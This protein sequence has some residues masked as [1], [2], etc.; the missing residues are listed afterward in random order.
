MHRWIQGQCSV[1]LTDL[2]LG[3]PLTS[4][5]PRGDWREF[6]DSRLSTGSC[7]NWH[8]TACKGQALKGQKH[9]SARQDRLLKYNGFQSVRLAQNPWVESGCWTPRTAVGEELAAQG[10]PRQCSLSLQAESDF[11]TGSGP[12][13]KRVQWPGK[14]MSLQAYS[15]PG[16]SSSV[17]GL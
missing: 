4:R 11:N 6:P 7:L 1:P 17:Q 14:L 15:Y 3:T 5:P 2:G 13:L 16:L 12:R 8:L 10:C 9:E